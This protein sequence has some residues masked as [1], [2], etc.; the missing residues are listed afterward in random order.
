MKMLVTKAFVEAVLDACNAML[1][2][3]SEIQRSPEYQAQ[4][5]VG[6]ILRFGVEKS[7]QNRALLED[8]ARR[9]TTELGA[10]A[11]ATVTP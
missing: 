8:W 6:D 5:Q 2:R 1:S 11:E 9:A 3:D 10:F 7:T 4:T